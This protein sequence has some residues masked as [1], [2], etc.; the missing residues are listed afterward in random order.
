[1]QSK[2]IEFANKSGKHLAYKSRNEKEN[3][4]EISKGATVLM[5][6]TATHTK[7]YISIILFCIK[8]IGFPRRN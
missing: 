5:D 8:D 7:K 4:M 2:K 3:N 1:M 6:N